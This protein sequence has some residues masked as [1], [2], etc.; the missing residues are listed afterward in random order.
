ME[1]DV[2]AV[3]S[4]LQVWGLEVVQTPTPMMDHT[5]QTSNA[6]WVEAGIHARN[7][8]PLFKD[9]VRGVCVMV[10]VLCVPTVS[11]IQQRSRVFLL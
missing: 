11:F 7:K 4:E 5:G 6:H 10:L 3:I 8:H 1:W 2:Q 9:V